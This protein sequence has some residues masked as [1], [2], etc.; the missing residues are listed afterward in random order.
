MFAPGFVERGGLGPCGL[1][2]APGF[3]GCCGLGF[4]GLGEGVGDLKFGEGILFV[5]LTFSF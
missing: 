3:A 1:E 2:A 4:C 5:Y